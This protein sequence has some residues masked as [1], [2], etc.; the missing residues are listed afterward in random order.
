[1]SL[2]LRSTS[3][4]RRFGRRRSLATWRTRISEKEPDVCRMR[5]RRLCGFAGALCE[6]CGDDG[7]CASAVWRGG[8]GCGTTHSSERS[9]SHG[10]LMFV[11]ARVRRCAETV[12]GDLLI[13]SNVRDASEM[14]A[15]SDVYSCRRTP[16]HATMG[17]DLRKERA[18][19]TTQRQSTHACK[20]PCDA[21]RRDR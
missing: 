17:G 1:M 2:R 11:V 3:P 4:L 13:C 14:G 19:Q 8:V 20:D 6:V 9:S 15:G 21:S 5:G 7:L 10:W 16:Q 12:G 18:R